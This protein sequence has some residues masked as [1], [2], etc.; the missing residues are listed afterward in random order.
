MKISEIQIQNWLQI[1][2]INLKP[3]QPVV[4]IA[5]GN[6]AGKSS[7][8]DA[9]EFALTKGAVRGISKKTDYG[10]LV[11]DGAKAGG[12]LV[13]VD[14]DVDNAFGFD[15]PKGN[16]TGPEITEAMRVALRGQ[17]FASMDLKERSKFIMSMSP[18]KP[19]PKT[20]LPMLLA[21]G[22]DQ[23]KAETVLPML[24]TGWE[25]AVT[26]AKEEATK[27]KG[28]FR[29]VS[30]LTWGKVQAEGWQAP[31]PDAPAVDA[32]ALKAAL[33]AHD[34]NT[35]KLNESLG[36][37]K[38]AQKQA[39]ADA[40]IRGELQA[41]ARRKPELETLLSAAIKERD[42]FQAKVEHMRERAKGGK[43]GLVHDL[44]RFIATIDVPLGI[45]AEE[46]GTV[47]I[48]RYEAEHGSIADNAVPCAEAAASLPD[49]ETGLTVMVNRAANLERDLKTASDNKVKYDSLAPAEGAVDASQ[50]I[51]EVE[52]LVEEARVKRIAIQNK[53]L[54][55]DAAIKG[56]AAAEQKTKDATKHHK[57]VLEWTLIADQ[58]SPSGIPAKLLADALAPINEKLEQAAIDTDWQRVVIGA[59]MEIKVGTHLYQMESVSSKWRADAMIAQAVSEVSGLKLLLLDGCDVLAIPAR[60]QLFSWV[61]MLAEMGAL[62][63]AILCATLK[64][65]PSGMPENFEMHWLA[66]GVIVSQEQQA[67]A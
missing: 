64:A 34:Q 26:F 13:V 41:S 22:A 3:A 66:D 44:A 67:A 39:A 31:M 49:H 12:A 6:M 28:A 46:Q 54:D 65:L 19:S 15:V 62:D 30:G 25:N 45:E 40:Q 50:E 1:R 51:A 47:L 48:N 4:L 63:T 8:A 60:A 52:A 27:A 53:I 24:L 10:M 42:T 43:Q 9:V 7:C 36:T 29:Q 38:Q 23:A 20:V 5:G 32:E 58:L 61:S 14:N 59:D 17:R 2:E 35:A 11:H 33:E 18:V 56:R 57:D 37:I 16:F 55:I 21:R